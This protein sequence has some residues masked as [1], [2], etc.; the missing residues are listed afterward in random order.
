[1]CTVVEVYARPAHTPINA[2]LYQA[3]CAAFDRPSAQTRL[4]E[5]E[6][7][8]AREEAAA[9]T[10]HMKQ[11]QALATSSDQALRDMQVHFL[12]LPRMRSQHLHCDVQ[13][14]FTNRRRAQFAPTVMDSDHGQIDLCTCRLRMTSTRP[15]QKHGKEDWLQ[16]RSK[17]I[18]SWKRPS[19][20]RR[21]RSSGHRSSRSN[22]M[23]NRRHTR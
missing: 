7:S 2:A 3:K 10:A 19:M 21:R 12:G 20:S 23:A 15:R 18:L 8:A 13:L 6:L 9:A 1:M 16:R 22:W 14:T 4:L 11:F 17:R 5:Q